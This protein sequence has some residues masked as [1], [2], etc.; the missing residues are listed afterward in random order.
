MDNKPILILGAGGHAKVIAEVL[1]K[2][3]K[4]ILGFVAPEIKKGSKYFNLDVLGDDS[5][6]A[7]YNPEEVLLANGVG[8]L[9][10]NTLRRQLAINMRQQGYRFATVIHPD[11]IVA[12]DVY[13][14][15]GV[16][17][18][19][20]VVIQPSVSVGKDTIV[21]T[22]ALIDHDCTI[23]EDCHIAP[24]VTLCGGVDIKSNVYVGAGATILQGISV[25]K[26]S[27]LAAGSIIYKDISEGVTYLQPRHSTT[28]N[29][30][31]INN[32]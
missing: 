7:S 30:E 23:A 21:N 31:D 11:S 28:S 2:S 18:M 19:A 14:D 20:G 17:I 13:L 6:L 27:I 10:N 3:G 5:V 1:I 16:Q 22:G 25:G 29:N 26:N 32:A 12:S 9:P 4:E 24:G 8:A 15:D